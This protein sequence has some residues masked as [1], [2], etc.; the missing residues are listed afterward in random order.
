RMMFSP[1]QPGLLH[2]FSLPRRIRAIR[3]TSMYVG[4]FHARILG[5]N[6]RA[7]PA[8]REQLKDLVDVDPLPADTR[9]AVA[10]VRI[11]RDSSKDLVAC[12]GALV[13]EGGSLGWEGNIWIV[14]Q[15][16]FP[17]ATGSSSKI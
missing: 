5:E 2:D 1:A 7:G 3:N 16:P 11:K 10:D 15:R 13:T 8:V 17:D 12:H 6:L 4:F 9:P 14:P